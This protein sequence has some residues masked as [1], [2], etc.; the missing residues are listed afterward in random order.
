M[1]QFVAHRSDHITR[2]A[3]KFGDGL[4]P[5]HHVQGR[6]LTPQSLL[7]AGKQIFIA[8]GY[9]LDNALLGFSEVMLDA[10]EGCE[11]SRVRAE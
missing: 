8:V 4:N 3:L 11:G 2:Q 7:H 5:R 10:D 1:R 9:L 6:Q